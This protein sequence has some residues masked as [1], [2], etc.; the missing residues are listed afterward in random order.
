MLE[1]GQVFLPLDAPW[2]PALL[3]EVFG[4]PNSRYDDQVDSV[5]QYLGWARER[6]AAS[7]FE[8]DFGFGDHPTAEDMFDRMR[9][10]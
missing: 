8:A 10:R 6:S 3:H 4:F 2:L 9:R 7:S 5:T 1:A